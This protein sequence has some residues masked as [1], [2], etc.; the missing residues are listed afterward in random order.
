MK[1]NTMRNKY[2][3]LPDKKNKLQQ[4][5]HLQHW[6]R[7]DCATTLQTSEGQ[8][9]QSKTS[10]ARQAIVHLAG[11]RKIFSDM[12]RFKSFFYSKQ[13]LRKWFEK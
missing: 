4:T 10:T 7:E 1:K 13:D 9:L 3:K 11:N 12:P 6:R 8:S 2:N 5:S